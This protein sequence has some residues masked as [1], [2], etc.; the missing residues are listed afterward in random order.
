MNVLSSWLAR[1]KSRRAARKLMRKLIA[2]M[3][4]EVAFRRKMREFWIDFGNTDFAAIWADYAASLRKDVDDLTIEEKKQ[5][6][7]NYV[8]RD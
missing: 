6:H 2:G 7:L 5:A 8:L 1:R 3:E 4:R